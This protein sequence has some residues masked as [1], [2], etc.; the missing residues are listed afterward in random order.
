MSKYVCATKR[1]AALNSYQ[2]LNITK[3]QYRNQQ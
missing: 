3:Y 1:S 2:L